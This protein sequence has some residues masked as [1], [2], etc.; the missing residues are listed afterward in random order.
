[1]TTHINGGVPGRNTPIEKGP[2]A[3]DSKALKSHINKRHFRIGGACRQT[4]NRCVN[5]I[6]LIA[7]YACYIRAKACFIVNKLFLFWLSI[8]PA[9]A[10]LST[11]FLPF[12]TSLQGVLQS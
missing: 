7:T 8:W 1:M 4:F 6:L 9:M 3:Y 2:G 11:C 12:I 10:A 5:A